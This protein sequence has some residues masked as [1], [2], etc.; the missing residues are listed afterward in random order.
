MIFALQHPAIN[1]SHSSPLPPTQYN[2]VNNTFK[3]HIATI[4]VKGELNANTNLFLFES[5]GIVD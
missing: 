3:N 1:K 2:I 5:I 4:A